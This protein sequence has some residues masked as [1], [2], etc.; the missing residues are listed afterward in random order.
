MRITPNTMD[1][2]WYNAA[3]AWKPRLRSP[4]RSQ[5]NCSG[6]FNFIGHMSR[7]IQDN[8]TFIILPCCSLKNANACLN[9]YLDCF[10]DTLHS[11]GGR[12]CSGVCMSFLSVCEL[13]GDIAGFLFSQV[14]SRACIEPVNICWMNKKK[15][16]MSLD[17]VE[18]YETGS[19]KT[20]YIILARELISWQLRGRQDTS[21]WHLERLELN[22]Y[23]ATT[24]S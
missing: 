8:L 1:M 5:M 13:E 7:R 20:T 19:E 14:P 3:S 10:Q 21:K 23:Q 15:I 9:M 4:G 6:Q 24:T 12:S 22:K 11:A 16:S 17:S 18:K 2:W